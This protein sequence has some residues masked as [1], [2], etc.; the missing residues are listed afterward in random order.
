MAQ[1]SRHWR[2]VY[3]LMQGFASNRLTFSYGEIAAPQILTSS[4][5]THD[6]NITV[7]SP[8]SSAPYSNMAPI[9]VSVKVG[10]GSGPMS[11][12]I[13]EQPQDWKVC[14]SWSSSAS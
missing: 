13:R 14:I 8:V 6:V 12:A 11:N 1:P 2:L 9:Q 3:L 10:L 4:A 7:I 5:T